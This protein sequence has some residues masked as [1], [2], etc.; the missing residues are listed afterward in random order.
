MNREILVKF[1][2][3]KYLSNFVNKGEIHFGSTKQYREI[4]EEEGNR[5]IGDKND[6]NLIYPNSELPHLHSFITVNNQQFSLNPKDITGF[7]SALDENIFCMTKISINDDLKSDESRNKFIW[8]ME[9]TLLADSQYP[10]KIV[11]LE[12][13]SNFLDALGQSLYVLGYSKESVVLS[14]IVYSDQR[15]EIANELSRRDGHKH[16]PSFWINFVKEIRFSSERELRLI[17]PSRGD[18]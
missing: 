13:W 16:G 1:E 2:D 17:I 3:P 8:E 15:Y 11:F 4:E 6:G 5:W 9:H 12:K 14:N 18:F 10:K 7:S